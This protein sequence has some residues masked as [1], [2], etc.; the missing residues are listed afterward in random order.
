[1]SGFSFAEL[2]HQFS[3]KL[4]TSDIE[5][6]NDSEAKNNYAEA[7]VFFIPLIKSASLP[8]SRS[9]FYSRTGSVSLSATKSSWEGLNA[10]IGGRVLKEAE[11]KHYSFNTFLANKN[12]P[13]WAELNYQH[14]DQMDYYFSNGTDI[15]FKSD[16][17]KAVYFGTYIGESL[18]IYGFYSKQKDKTYGAGL[19]KLFDLSSIGFL[20][21]KIELS[22]TNR[23]Y[24]D[25]RIVNDIDLDIPIFRMNERV[26]Y[27][28]LSY[29][30]I[31]ATSLSL[32]YRQVGFDSGH[33][34]NHYYY[35]DMNHYLTDAL[36]LGIHYSHKDDLDWFSIGGYDVLGLNLG[37]D[38]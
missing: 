19:V 17:V 10:V 18:S 21:A 23:N 24:N 37:F 26:G 33:R 22:K 20:E 32:A 27:F 6:D 35:A 31:P 15:E 36:Q 5:Y 3:L 13:V 1:L 28:Q 25:I 2:T 12:I 16:S 34:K 8:Y 29:F 9:A 11:T 30:P 38:F 4:S 14:L 7:T